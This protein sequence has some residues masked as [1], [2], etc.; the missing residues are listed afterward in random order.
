MNLHAT[1]V[2]GLGWA[3]WD[4][5]TVQPNASRLLALVVFGKTKDISCAR[6]TCKNQLV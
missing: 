4:T 2:A 5:Q 3:D 1:Q 6:D